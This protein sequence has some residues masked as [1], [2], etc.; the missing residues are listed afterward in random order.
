VSA[1]LALWPACGFGRPELPRG[2]REKTINATLWI[3][4]IVLA[5]AFV[6]TGVLK[7]SQGKK[8]QD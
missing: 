3:I 8:L 2:P 4:Q 7:L 5:A 1:L 6:M